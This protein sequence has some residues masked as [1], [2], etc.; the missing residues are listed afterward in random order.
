[1]YLVIG[2]GNPGDEYKN[3]KHN[4]GR[5]I[6]E[7]WAKKNDL[8]DFAFDKKHNAL[9]AQGKIDKEKT[10]AALP[11][12]F[13][14]KSGL[15]VF[16]LASYYKVKP[17]Q[18]FVVH[19]DIDLPVGRIKLSFAKNSAGHKG[20]EHVTKYLKTTAYWR[21]RIGIGSAA[22][23]KTKQAMDVVLKKFSAK[24]ELDIKKAVKKALEAL[25]SAVAESPEKAMS[26]YN[27]S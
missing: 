6:V 13:M 25:T 7:K 21:V 24:E 23:K 1:M 15:A 4:I 27:Q 9:V 8:G 16:A 22:K 14:N 20:V 2:L 18:I 5:E 11:E 17:V 19:D 12:T 26:I 3:T 10:V